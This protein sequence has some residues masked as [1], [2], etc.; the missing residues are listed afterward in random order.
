MDGC[1]HSNHALLHHWN[2]LFYRSSLHNK[3]CWKTNGFSRSITVQNI[4]YCSQHFLD[5]ARTWTNLKFSRVSKSLNTSVVTPRLD[6]RGPNSGSFYFCPKKPNLLSI[7]SSLN[8]LF[9]FSERRIQGN[10]LIKP[11]HWLNNCQSKKMFQRHLEEVHQ[12]WIVLKHKT[13]GQFF[14]NQSITAFAIS[15]HLKIL[16][17]SRSFFKPKSKEVFCIFQKNSEEI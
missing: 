4:P 1:S 14:L 6:P 11:L 8:L 12:T 16:N 7:I 5:T 9:S 15:L 2:L 10:Y 3:Y 17:S 13:F